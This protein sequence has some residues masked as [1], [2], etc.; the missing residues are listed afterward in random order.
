MNYTGPF[1]PG[2]AA[3]N[4]SDPI[5]ALLGSP[6]A[7]FIDHCVT[8]MEDRQMTPAADW[9]EQVLDFHRF[10]CVDDKQVHTEYSALRSTVMTDFDRV[11]KLPINEPAAGK[12]KSQIQEYVEYHGG[13][14]IQHIALN[15]A[16]LISTVRNLKTRG[17]SFLP[18]PSSYY[19][20]LLQRLRRQLVIGVDDLGDVG[21]ADVQRRRDR[22]DSLRAVHGL[23]L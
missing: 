16:D 4:S 21:L 14:G 23:L 19:V 22:I 5:A 13:P 18:V 1:L 10:W 8:N 3:V 2:F 12:K 20:D 9:Y 7:L 17:V 6:N 11:I 15:T